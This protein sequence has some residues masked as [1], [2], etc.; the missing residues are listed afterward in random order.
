M[1]IAL[2]VVSLIMILAI[3]FNKKTSL[4]NIIKDQFS[5]YKNDKINKIFF[6]DILT[7]YIIPVILAMLIA[8]LLE[9][10]DFLEKTELLITIFSV[11][12]TVLLSFLAIL[13]GVKY[14][15]QSKGEQVLKETFLT[16]IMDVVYSLI[17]VIS[18]LCVSFCSV[19]G[20][21][22]NFVIGIEFY[23]IIKTALNM[24][25]ILKRMYILIKLKE[26]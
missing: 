9:Y 7:F 11:I 22:K 16:I 12:A 1:K 6:Y 10:K 20:I 8:F 23:F 15:K 26:K 13:V 18:L 2:I 14:E 4:F 5:T 24:L 21:G 19:T 3:V 17:I 25:L